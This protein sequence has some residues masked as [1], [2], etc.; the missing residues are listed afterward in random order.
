MIRLF[1][2]TL[3]TASFHYK[4]KKK[5]DNKIVTSLCN[6]IYTTQLSNDYNVNATASSHNL[7]KNGIRY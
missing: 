6:R 7:I 3:R 5:T 1:L 2:N 4:K